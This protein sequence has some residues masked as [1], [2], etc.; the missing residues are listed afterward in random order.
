M[1]QS[2]WIRQWWNYHFIL[3]DHLILHPMLDQS[4]WDETTQTHDQWPQWDNVWTLVAWAGILYSA[5]WVSSITSLLCICL[6]KQWHKP[7]QCDHLSEGACK[8]NLI[9]SGYKQ[10]KIVFGE[11]WGRSDCSGRCIQ[12][13]ISESVMFCL[14]SVCWSVSVSLT[15]VWSLSSLSSSVS[16][17]SL[18]QG[19][20]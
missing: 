7:A 14:C 6:H 1:Q 17:L 13:I 10:W 2:A 15:I 5:W 19:V 3:C 16:L 18:H 4:V 12:W 20:T 8:V 11:V 9:F